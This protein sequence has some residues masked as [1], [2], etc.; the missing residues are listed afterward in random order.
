[1]ENQKQFIEK[2]HELG[3]FFDEAME[4]EQ[5]VGS[6]LY[7]VRDKNVYKKFYGFADKS[8]QQATN[9]QTIYSP[10]ISSQS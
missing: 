4:R 1:M 9:E 3:N 5:M 8:S 6:S 7:F 2:W 10:Y